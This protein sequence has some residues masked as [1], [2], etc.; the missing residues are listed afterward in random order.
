MKASYSVG[1]VNPIIM[2]YDINIFLRNIKK[3]LFSKLFEKK[4]SFL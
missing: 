4:Y 1:W 3:I 2:K